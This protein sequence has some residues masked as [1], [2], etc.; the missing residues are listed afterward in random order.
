MKKF[1]Q[2]FVI[3]S[4]S[5]VKKYKNHLLEHIKNILKLK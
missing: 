5:E 4:Q 3:V 1:N 2:S